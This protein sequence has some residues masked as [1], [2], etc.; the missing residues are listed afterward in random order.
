MTSLCRLAAA[1]TTSPTTS[2][3]STRP[4]RSAGVTTDHLTALRMQAIAR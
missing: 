4:Q 2:P 1:L 3:C